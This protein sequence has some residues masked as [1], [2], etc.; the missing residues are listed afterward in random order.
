[1]DLRNILITLLLENPKG[2]SLKA[3]E[4][5]VGDTHPNSGK[6]I[7]TIIKKIATY[8]APGRYILIPGVEQESFKKPLSESGSSPESNHEQILI[9]D[10]EK[11]TA[12]EI[13]QQN[14]LNSKIEEESHIVEKIDIEQT[15][16]NVAES[17]RKVGSNCEEKQ[18][19]SSGSGSESDS[20]S[21]SSDSSDSGS[22]SRSRSKSK[23]PM[24]SGSGSS[25]DSESDGSS[26][27][28][29]GSDVDVDIMTS[30][31]DKKEAVNHFTKISPS[32]NTSRGY[33]DRE[34]HNAADEIKDDRQASLSYLHLSHPE[35][36]E[37]ISDE[38]EVVANLA[39]N[40]NNN[41]KTSEG[42]DIKMSERNNQ[43][44]A[45][46]SNSLIVDEIMPDPLDQCKQSEG[47]SM[48]IVGSSDNDARTCTTK[49][50]VNDKQSTGQINPRYESPHAA[51]TVSKV[52]S[53]RASD[54][55]LIPEKKGIVKKPK[56]TSSLKEG[57]GKG[58][59]RWRSMSPEIH[60]QDQYKDQVDGTRFPESQGQSAALVPGKMAVNAK[61]KLHDLSE[62]HG[63]Y[64]QRHG[65]RSFSIPD[66]SDGPVLRSLPPKDSFTVL[67]DK[68]QKGSEKSLSKNVKEGASADRLCSLSDSHYRIS[69]EQS[70]M[71]QDAGQTLQVR[72]G[73]FPKDNY[74]SN[75]D[76]FPVVTGKGNILKRELSDLELGEFREPLSGEESQ[77]AKGFERKN[78]FKLADKK[79]NAPDNFSLD[80]GKERNTAKMI[81]ESKRQSPINLIDGS[82]VNQDKYCRRMPDEGNV[83]PTMHQPWL[84]SSQTQ[85]NSSVQCV[86]YEVASQS[87][88][89]S[90]VVGAS[91]RNEVRLSKGMALDNHGSLLKK[92]PASISQQDMKQGGQAV[93]PK[94]GREVKPQKIEMEFD[95]NGRRKDR[96]GTESSTNGGKRRE[97]SSDDDSSFY[98]MYD[99]DE[100][101]LKG[102]I[103]DYVQYKEYVKEYCEKYDRYSSLNKNLESYRREFQK[104]GRELE[105]AKSRD[106]EG[107]YN[108]LEQIKETYRQCGT[109]H[110]RM[111]K[112]FVVLHEELKH[113]KQRIK[114]FA[115]KY[116]KE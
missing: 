1:M 29:E 113:L 52:K 6:R 94:T 17:D 15:S 31:D 107:Y 18:G 41:M 55:M 116:T 91:I 67:K 71:P 38:V 48:S 82:D 90:D 47:L 32:P 53:R 81:H 101:E 30:D 45:C 28:K 92:V 110:K 13:E 10:M 63:R 85:Q 35:K 83:D 42:N 102:P 37:D 66:E 43:L 24:G 8:Q 62:G 26:S 7:E 106:A 95:S 93:I 21:D 36:F 114:D 20:E 16:P 73:V 74:R 33:H 12:E 78:S 44:I 97:S 11:A 49:L 61:G 69:D 98:T 40:N 86:D 57:I 22:P 109:R 64:V 84:L 108:V 112:I 54:P 56:L 19:S 34:E 39:S 103:K 104:L 25:S 76:K 14:V 65:E 5:A 27:S 115:Q 23:S 59:D 96:F 70:G 111:K 2:M 72:A 60:D 80:S 79:V 87:D 89:L 9:T 51:S 3:L 58:K 105:L 88:N 46:Q 50:T 75:M 4:K 99:K 77:G 100:P 68:P